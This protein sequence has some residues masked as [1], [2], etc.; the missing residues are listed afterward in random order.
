[1][2]VINILTPQEAK[3]I[4]I[5]LDNGALKSKNCTVTVNFNSE[6]EI[7]SIEKKEVLYKLK[8]AS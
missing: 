2:D 5:L 1:M 4:N 7:G 6:G 8:Y 3:N